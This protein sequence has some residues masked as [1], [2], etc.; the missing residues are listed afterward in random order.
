MLQFLVINLAKDTAR[1]KAFRLRHREWMDAVKHCS[2]IEGIEG[3]KHKAAAFVPGV[4]RPSARAAKRAPRAM[5]RALRGPMDGD[6]GTMISHVKAWRAAAN[7]PPGV[8]ATVVMEDDAVMPRHA[9]QAMQAVIDNAPPGWQWLN[10]F[11]NRRMAGKPVP[12]H[13]AYWK[14]AGVVKPGLNTGGVAYIVTP[15]GARAVLRDALPLPFPLPAGPDHMLK[16]LWGKSLSIFFHSGKLVRH[17]GDGPSTRRTMN[18]QVRK[19]V[20]TA[21]RPRQTR[22]PAGR[23]Q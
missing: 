7:P 6:H 3:L 14:P 8:T 19:G 2:R 20:T 22:R 5:R 17:A 21:R 23:R 12:G 10:L 4:F 15:A 11:C 13:P 1:W 9:P 16:R 18:K